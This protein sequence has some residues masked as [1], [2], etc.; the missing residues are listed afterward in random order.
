MRAI[1]TV[2]AD[3]IRSCLTKSRDLLL[4]T[5]VDTGSLIG[6][7]QFLRDSDRIGTYGTACGLIAYCAVAPEDSDIIHR[8]AKGLATRQLEN[9][10]WDSPT[11]ASGVG[12][13]TATCYSSMALRRSG[14]IGSAESLEKAAAW[15]RSVTGVN[16][17]VSPCLGMQTYTVVCS[18]LALR[19]LVELGIEYNSSTVNRIAWWLQNAQNA[20]GG[21]GE[22]RDA[23]S[24]IHHTAEAILALCAVRQAI[25][26][27]RETLQSAEAYLHSSWELGQNAHKDVV[28]IRDGDREVMLPHTFQS[29]G[30]LMQAELCFADIGFES[31]LKEMANWL[32]RQQKQ[33]GWRHNAVPG[34]TPSWAIMESVVGLSEYLRS[35]HFSPSGIKRDRRGHEEVGILVLAT[36]WDSVH[37]GLSTFN[38]ELCA[39]IARHDRRVVCFVPKASLEEINAAAALK[40]RLITPTI[41]ANHDPDE[42]LLF[43]RPVLPP[44]FKVSLVIGHG[45]ITGVHAE[46]QIKDNFPSARRIHFVHMIAEEIEWYKGKDNASQVVER[47]MKQ[48]KTLCLGA[49]I[50]ATVG[51]RID[52]E[53]RTLLHG[54]VPDLKICRVDPGM[55]DEIRV[56]LSPPPGIQCLL[57]GRAEDLE[58]KGLDIAAKAVAELP[59]PLPRPFESDPILVVRGAPAGSGASLRE[60]LLKIAGKMID[61]RVREYSACVDHIRDDLMKASVLLMPSRVE[62]FG[63]VATE[64]VSLGVPILASSRSGFAEL[65]IE[66][67]GSVSSQ[68]FVVQMTG[69]LDED[70]SNWSRLL[71]NVLRDRKAAFG[72]AYNLRAEIG[73]SLSW[74]AAADSLL[75]ACE[76][77]S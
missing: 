66:K 71:E 64:A 37:G 22:T 14:V 53:I 20:D 15:L 74:D 40:V 23:Q 25:P 65:V 17:G 28:Y 76:I 49:T 16:G 46:A 56:P 21:F 18:S 31:R 55:I 38:R 27:T 47:R 50:V 57:L 2:S 6:W 24:T 72:R 54:H 75:R 11:I 10:A 63:L 77:S 36:E 70:A 44:D 32:V 69:K 29:D 41:P 19:T 45:R 51:P 4:R 59:H 13:T 12:L 68:Q 8:V 42:S 43:R 3:D 7:R 73:S 35:S 34:K 58:L 52:R 30:L 39:A 5:L 33:G 60:K 61:I 67:L 48:E 1:S 26:G 62:G 9:G